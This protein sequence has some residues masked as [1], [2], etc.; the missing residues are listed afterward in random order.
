[1]KITKVADPKG[2]CQSCNVRDI[3]VRLRFEA[4]EYGEF[5]EVFWLCRDCSSLADGV[6]GVKEALVQLSNWR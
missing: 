3:E 5:G 6:S 4:T 1:M 2:R